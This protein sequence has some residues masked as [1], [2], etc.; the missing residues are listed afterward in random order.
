MKL[1]LLKIAIGMLLSIVYLNGN[2]QTLKQTIR[3]RVVDK[4]TE[5]PL[6]GVTLYIE[7]S[8][9]LIGTITD[10]DGFFSFSALPIGRYNVVVDYIG[11]EKIIVPNILIGAGKEAVISVELVESVTQVDEVTIRGR[12]KKGESLNDMT[13]VS[14]RSFTVEE[15]QRFAG[16]FADPSRMVSSY[17]GVMG[18]PNGENNIIIRGNSP[19]GLLWRV[20]GI[21]VPNPNHFSDEGATG[22]PISILNSTTLSNSDFLTGAFP[23]EYGDAYS[24]VFDI[25]LR[26]GNSEKREYTLQAGLIGIELAA[27]GPFQKDKTASYLVNYRYSSLDLINRIGIEVVGNAVPKFQ[28]LTFNLNIPIQNFGTLQIFGI[29]GISSIYMKEKDFINKQ[30]ITMGV[31]GINHLLPISRKTYLKSSF[32]ASTSMGDFRYEEFIAESDQMELYGQ[33]QIDYLNVRGSVEIFHKFSAKHTVK[34]GASVYS[35]NF[36]FFLDAYNYD[37]DKLEN[38][39]ND[40]GRTELTQAF[41]SWKYRPV[42]TFTINTG[43]HYTYLSL[44]GKYTIEPRFGFKWQAALRHSFSFGF[45]EHSRMENV[46]IYMG[47]ML[48]DDTYKQ[49]NKDLDFIKARHYVAGYDYRISQNVNLKIEAYYQELFDVPIEN[50][51]LSY[52]SILNEDAGYVFVD[53]VN[54]GKGKNY[55]S[56]IT[57]EKFFDKNYYFLITSSVF[58]SKYTPMDGIERNSRYS[59]NYIFNFVGGKEFPVGKN[60][61]NAIAINLRTTYAGGQNYSPIDP[62]QS[63]EAGYGIRPAE[64]AYSKKRSNYFRPDIKVSY[65]RNKK[66]STRIWELDIQNFTN[67]LNVTHDWWNNNEQKVEKFTQLGILPVVNYRIEF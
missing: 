53:L 11:Y 35:K 13:T 36:E 37:E 39:L 12:K 34:S 4:D 22:G 61:N 30:G 43:V 55:G 27:E 32:S 67:T 3:G 51:P 10:E 50:D 31:A 21:D 29:G 62:V 52:Y 1:K 16:S 63:L 18:E 46:S 20:E 24:G 28:D 23:A 2:A 44:N 57:L 8:S 7:N 40:K 60:K 38:K 15:T 56:E 14:A 65:R 66:N 6:I 58:E 47:K 48:I 49:L 41:V 45:G 42:Q 64:T 19:R 9:P 5:T 59:G 25:R 26:K 54:N 33:E 17:A